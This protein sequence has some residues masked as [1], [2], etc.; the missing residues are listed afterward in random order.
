[1]VFSFKYNEIIN[2]RS[3][4]IVYR[5]QPPLI[6]AITHDIIITNPIYIVNFVPNCIG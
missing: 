2:K 1:M 3:P 4:D 5:Y 6:N